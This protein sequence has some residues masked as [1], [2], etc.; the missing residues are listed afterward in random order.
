MLEHLKAPFP[1]MGGKS[2]VAHEI[3]KRIGNTVNYVEPFCGSAAVLLSRPE[4]GK[5]ETINDY[6]CLI[7][8][9]WR[10]LGSDPD[11][12]AFHADNPVC[13]ADLHARQV[14]LINRKPELREQIYN[15]TDYCDPKAA[16]WWIW[17]MSCWIG[18]GF[19]ATKP[20]QKVP[21]LTKVQGINAMAFR[22]P[23]LGRDNGVINK[24]ENLREYF[25]NLADRLRHVRRCC[26]D[27]ERVLTPAVTTYHGL[28]AVFLDPPYADTAARTANLYA[29]DDLQVAH[30]AR[31][32]ALANGDNPLFRICLAG[33]DG[34]HTIPETWECLSW[35]TQGGYGNQ[36]DATGKKNRDRERLWFSPH[37][38]KAQQE[39]E[40]L[41]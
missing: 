31:Q 33:Y 38:L 5:V 35:K 32:W 25:Q 10:A 1:Y 37:C 4:I 34:E 17:G 40:K 6:D 12:V 27:F 28:T 8:N 21:I 24:S 30:R 41:F 9:L 20:V 3:W 18:G 22:R 11:A 16:G 29:E 13:E 19:C 7:A 26:G 15:D 23:H 36:A 39:Q 14:W 2:L